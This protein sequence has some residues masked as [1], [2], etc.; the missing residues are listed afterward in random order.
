VPDKPGEGHNK[1]VTATFELAVVGRPPLGAQFFGD[2]V[3][4][5]MTEAE[6]ELTELGGSGVYRDSVQVEWGVERG[7]GMGVRYEGL[8]DLV[9]NF[10]L[11]AFNQDKTFSSNISWDQLYQ[12]RSQ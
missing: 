12:W 4:G 6:A 9:E 3:R 5:M 1:K 10:G 2:V 7:V 11:V 8:S